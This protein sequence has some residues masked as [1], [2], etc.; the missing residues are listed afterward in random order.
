MSI[1]RSYMS[2]FMGR[3]ARQ[4]PR[5][6]QEAEKI[7]LKHKKTVKGALAK[8]EEGGQTT[9]RLGTSSVVESDLKTSEE[10]PIN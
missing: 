7:F 4:S 9:H 1:G 8:F 6:K 3:R 10:D 2:S 5:K